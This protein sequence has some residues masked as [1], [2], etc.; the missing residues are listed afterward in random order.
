MKEQGK[1]L[2][3]LLKLLTHVDKMYSRSDKT[4][5]LSTILLLSGQ[6]RIPLIQIICGPYVFIII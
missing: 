5:I 3:E 2:L 1:V 6:S 4:T